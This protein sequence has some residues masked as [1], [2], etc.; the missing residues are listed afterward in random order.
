MILEQEAPPPALPLLILQLLL[1]MFKS[2][3]K[4]SVGETT[5]VQVLDDC[6]GKHYIEIL[7]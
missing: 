7:C 1:C 4:L 5:G 6:R 2:V 3:I